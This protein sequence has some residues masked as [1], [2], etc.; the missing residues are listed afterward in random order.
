ML[1]SVDAR[2]P[3]SFHIYVSSRHAA[4]FSGGRALRCQLRLIAIAAEYAF[5]GRAYDMFFLMLIFIISSPDSREL[6][7]TQRC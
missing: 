7:F 5:A 2:Q 1:T 3:C 6:R 4:V